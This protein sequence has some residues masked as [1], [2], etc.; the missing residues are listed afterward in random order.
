ML[1]LFERAEDARKGVVDGAR[2]LD[3]ILAMGDSPY[4]W[5]VD[6]WG[7]CHCPDG[8]NCQGAVLLNPTGRS[9]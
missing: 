4:L 2:N 7:S 8:A 5:T 1:V 9:V 3:R 6:M